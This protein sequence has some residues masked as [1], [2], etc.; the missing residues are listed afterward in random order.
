M[1]KKALFF[2]DI[3]ITSNQDPKYQTLLDQIRAVSVNEISHIFLLGDIFDLWIADRTYF[4]DQYKEL[5]IEFKKCIRD[6]IK[7]YYFEGNHDLYLKNFWQQ[8]VGM[9][10]CH[11]ALDVELGDQKFRLEHGDQM[12]QEDRGYLFLRWFLRTPLM[13]WVAHNIPE[14]WI[15]KLGEWSSKKSRHYTS[16]VKTIQE[17]ESTQKMIAH[18]KQV[19]KLKAFDVFIC[20]HTHVKHQEK[21][22]MYNNN[23][24]L[25]VNLGSWYD[26]PKYFEYSSPT[27]YSFK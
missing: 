8:E 12:D 20:G 5:I 1:F 25:I 21:V 22:K 26:A 10:V 7:L 24:A 2:S 15:V 4:L 16:A 13:K 27:N 14:K 3:H 18:A 17:N 11:E 6:G 23:E 19:Y 9:I